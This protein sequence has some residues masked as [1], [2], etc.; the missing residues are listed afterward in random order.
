[1]SDTAKLRAPK[2]AP[3]ERW[4]ERV[5]PRSYSSRV[6]GRELTRHKAVSNLS[7]TVR[8]QL[9]GLLDR[10]LRTDD[11]LERRAAGRRGQ[12][13]RVSRREAA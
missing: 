11:S 3:G 5:R 2:S 12:A 13:G 7:D 9:A 8:R 6:L 4:T 1:M 10:L